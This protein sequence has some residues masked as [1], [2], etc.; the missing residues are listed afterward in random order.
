MENPNKE[1]SIA[2][3]PF[4]D[5]SL[6]DDA[7]IF[8]KSFCMDLIIELSCFKQFNIIAYQSGSLITTNNGMDYQKLEELNI[9]Y[10]LI[11]S[12]RNTNETIRINAQL[13]HYHTNRLIWAD[14][15]E[16]KLKKLI[17]VQQLLLKRIVA[18]LQGQINED[19]KSQL[20]KKQ[21]ISLSAYELWLKGIDTLKKGTKNSD[22]LARTYFTKALEMEPEYSLAYSGM[23]LTYLNE[24]SCEAWDKWDVN[25]NEA[26]EWA[27]KAIELDEQNYIAALVI[28]RVL[29]YENSFESAEYF[30][31]RS[32]ELNSN[33][34]GTL[35]E[36]ASCLVF[37]GKPED[38]I[39]CFN[40]AI[41]INPFNVN[42]YN[43]IGAFIYLENGDF[44]KAKSYAKNSF[45]AKWFDI[46]AFF[47]AIDYYL[48]DF[49]SMEKNWSC[50]I[51]SYTQLIN[52]KNEV[53]TKE[54]VVW[55]QMITPYK[56][57]SYMTNFWEYMVGG[58]DFMFPKKNTTSLVK[59]KI[60]VFK[61]KDDKWVITFNGMSTNLKEK[62]GFYDIQKLIGT[63]NKEFYCGDLMQTEVVEKGVN[64]IDLKA[65]EDYQ[66]RINN[67]Q[68]ELQEADEN[69]DFD[70]IK[71]LHEEYDQ[72]VDYITK[73]YD[74]HG[75][76]RKTGDGTN[77]LRSAVTWRIR[78]AIMEIEKRN[79]LLGKH[80]N[81][82]IKTGAYCKYEPE[83]EILW[84]CD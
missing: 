24:W 12:F 16:N 54:A 4:E 76:I 64:I 82:S 37:L 25:K 73:S 44:L 67:I 20:R 41:K 74:I 26:Y 50:F 19:L 35:V 13:Y 7:S 59:D 53:S 3:L 32:F 17:N 68:E 34:P 30:I 5:L 28:G 69:S 84:E 46:Y 31:H 6:N 29:L 22:R 2:I 57:K 66:K 51:K 56:G 23:S 48:K 36:I 27:K 81:N 43:S 42:Q 39:N 18:A 38:A 70:K 14:R 9:D 62:K 83:F 72:I 65:K 21:P 8:C 49:D 60:G 45:G 40:K 75:R 11:G 71:S 47:A 52:A 79:P 10:Y 55:M 58:H 77:K 78:N 61:K 1:I 15:F 33:D 63:P 80:L